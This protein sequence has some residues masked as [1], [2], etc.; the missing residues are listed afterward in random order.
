MATT[1]ENL[2]SNVA[3]DKRLGRIEQQLDRVAALAAV[4]PNGPFG[5][6]LQAD[7][8]EIDLRELWNV[9][10]QGKW[11]I[12]AVTFVFA[13]VSVI[14][15]LSQPNIYKSEALLAP[16]EENSGGG[17]AGLAG[18]FGGLAS[19]AGVNLGGGGTNKTTL[20][21]E[22]LKS[23]EFISTF[24][25]K[26]D[27]LVPLMAAEGWNSRAGE[28][29]ID[30]DIYDTVNSR[31][32]RD[33][34]PPRASQP[35][36]QEAYKEFLSRLKVVEDK[37]SSFVT[38]GFEYYSPKSSKQWV[39]DLVADINIEIK[40]RDVAEAEK[41]IQYLTE[42]LVKTS[43]ADMKTIFYELIEEQSKIVMFAE[44]RDEY[45]F[46]TIDPAIVPELKS[47]PKRALIVFFGAMLGGMCAI[48]FV[49]GRRLS[50]TKK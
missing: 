16:A 50:D 40:A 12:V 4:Q 49:L 45:V 20:A 32:V 39:D 13:V 48:I 46:K 14:Y 10:W 8:D 36:L 5:H 11:L 21:I 42:Q 22:V 26:H 43:V 15:A 28:L 9:I 18:Q 19:L 34:S 7:A 31:W 41:S 23:R 37:T 24:I 17:L 25:Q 33:V 3:I 38:I 1:S 44:V 29:L 6:Q 2:G 30:P 27:L 47:K 35:S